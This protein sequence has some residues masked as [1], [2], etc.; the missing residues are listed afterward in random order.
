MS[1]TLFTNVKI[2]DGSGSEPYQG[3][4][5]V[6]GNRIKSIGGGSSRITPDGTTVVDV[7]FTHARSPDFCRPRHRSARGERIL[8]RNYGEWAVPPQNASTTSSG[9][10]GAPVVEPANLL[11][12]PCLP[13]RRRLDAPTLPVNR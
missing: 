3:E 9:S 12:S 2:F 4:V 8:R 13:H 6:H 10:S 11:H 5:L 7:I 1:D